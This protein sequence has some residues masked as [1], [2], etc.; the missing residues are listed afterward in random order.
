MCIDRERF[1]SFCRV[2]GATSGLHL[3]AV[4]YLLASQNQTNTNFKAFLKE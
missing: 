3:K 1:K 4:T 2:F